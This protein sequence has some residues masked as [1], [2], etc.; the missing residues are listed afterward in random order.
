ML[1]AQKVTF[2]RSNDSPAQVAVKSFSLQLRLAKEQ[3]RGAFQKPYRAN[4][5]FQ[6]SF[7]SVN[8]IIP[9]QISK[10]VCVLQHLS[11]SSQGPGTAGPL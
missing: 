3:G 6:F 9:T 5:Q 1:S 8:V 10:Q 11:T 2:N 4:K 7:I